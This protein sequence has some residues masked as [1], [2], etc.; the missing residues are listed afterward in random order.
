MHVGKLQSGKL[1]VWQNRTSPLSSL[2]TSKVVI[3]MA[4]YTRGAKAHRDQLNKIFERV[5]S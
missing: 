5:Q 4:S 3:L 2:L 1:F